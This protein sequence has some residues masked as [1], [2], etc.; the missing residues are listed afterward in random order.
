MTGI[1]PS[2]LKHVLLLAVGHTFFAELPRV[3]A[4]HQSYS[5]S[6]DRALNQPTSQKAN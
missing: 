6:H 2:L 5:P 1:K 4:N 3:A